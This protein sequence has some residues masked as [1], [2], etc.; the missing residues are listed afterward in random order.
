[1]ANGCS[2]RGVPRP[3]LLRYRPRIDAFTASRVDVRACLA[4]P[5]GRPAA[6]VEVGRVDLRDSR[7]LRGEQLPQALTTDRATAGGSRTGRMPDAGRP[8]QGGSLVMW[9]T[10]RAPFPGGDRHV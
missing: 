7:A 5:T 3:P 10:C 4:A 1:M 6:P 9:R 2:L 8:P